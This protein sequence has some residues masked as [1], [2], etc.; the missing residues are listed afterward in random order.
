MVLVGKYSFK[1][2]NRDILTLLS[3]PSGDLHG[4]LVT[5]K[6]YF[7]IQSLLTGPAGLDSVFCIMYGNSMITICMVLVGKYSFKGPNRDIL[8]LF[9]FTFG[10]PWWPPVISEMGLKLLNKPSFMLAKLLLTLFTK[11]SSS[12]FKQSCTFYEF[13]NTG[14]Q[15]WYQISYLQLNI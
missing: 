1:G 2:P 6:K 13:I 11:D 12:P 8:T 5:K 9:R 10:Q 7:W 3:C 4:L 15:L 14:R